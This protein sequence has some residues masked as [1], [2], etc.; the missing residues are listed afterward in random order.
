[1]RHRLRSRVPLAIAALLVAPLFVAPAVDAGGPASPYVVV[2]RDTVAVD[3][4]ARQATIDHR[5]RANLRFQHAVRGFSA[6]LTPAQRQTMERDPSVEMVTPDSIVRLDAQTLPTGVNRVQADL[7]PAALIN[8]RDERVNADIAIID[9]GIQRDHPDLNVVGGYNCTSRYRSAWGDANGHGTHVAGVAAAKDNSF[10]VVG[11]AP[12][13]RLW[14]VRVFQPS[15][16]SRISWIVCGIDWITGL[17]DPLDPSRPRIEVANMSLRDAGY[18]DGNCGRSNSDAEH[19]AICRSVTAGTTYVVSSGNDRGW[20]QRWRPASYDE[21][22]T[23]SALADF[24]GRPGGRR[25]STCT[26]FG[27]PDRDDTFA[28]FSN[29]GADVDLIAPGKCIRST[30]RGSG[31]AWITGTSMSSPAVAGGAA[32]Y[33]ATHPGAGPAEIRLA[34]R[35]A[36]SLDWSTSTDPDGRP[37]PLLDVS[38]I[39]GGESIG[40]RVGATTLRGWA[41][42]ARFRV[43]IRVIRRDG[44]DGPVALD[45][46]GLPGGVAASWDRDRLSGLDEVAAFLTLDVGRGAVGGTYPLTIRATGAGTERAVVVNLAVLVDGAAP[47]VSAP[48]D[49]LLLRGQVGPTAPVRV[50]WAAS[51]AGS[52]ITAQELGQSRDGGEFAAVG[53]AA[54]T[55]AIVRHFSLGTAYQYRLRATDRTSNASDWRTGAPFVLAGYPETRAAYAGR[56]ATHVHSSSWGGRLRY[57]SSRGASV[58]FR[59]AGR[60]VGWVAPMSRGRGWARVYVDGRFVARISLYSRVGSPRRIVFTRSWLRSATHTI[61]I[62]N[63]GTPGRPRIDVDGFVVRR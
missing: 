60:E 38:G 52:G 28:D 62:V 15:G 39:G 24:D 57:A 14:A 47:V 35:A 61:R 59:F 34:L 44:F 48:T 9:T 23:V 8:G 6:F 26:S 3:G 40:L 43:P 32:L 2:L 50:S 30:Y 16:F 41:G 36:G 18:D 46:A 7:S 27:T 22:I 29:Y 55:R 63:E 11:V 10:G 20:A 53:V 37:E 1:V 5:I 42:I 51:D 31:Y 33:A 49:R 25:A 21:V 45:V 17:R 12:G 4:F 13:A 58:T 19:L 56:W 54:A